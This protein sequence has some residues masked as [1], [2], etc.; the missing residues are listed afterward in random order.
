[1]SDTTVSD[2]K[3]NRVSYDPPYCYF[4]GR[5]LKFNAKKNNTGRCTLLDVCLCESSWVRMPFSAW[6]HTLAGLTS[7]RV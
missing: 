2:D 6:D 5:S 1:M 7:T 3:Q 4:E